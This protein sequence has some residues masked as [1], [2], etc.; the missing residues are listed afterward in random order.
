MANSRWLTPGVLLLLFLFV[1]VMP[2]L[3]LFVSGYWGW[4]EAWI[5]AGVYILGFVVSRVLV[6]RRFPDL[7]A[8]RA[9]SMH[10]KDAKSWDRKLAPMLNLVAAVMLAVIGLD[11]RLNG[12]HPFPVWVIGLA[13]AAILAGWWAS[14]FSPCWSP[15]NT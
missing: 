5:Y 3:P 12:L 13:L 11:V 14:V 1:V 4:V 7:L 8:E 9:Q 2:M 15:T 10:M 6:A